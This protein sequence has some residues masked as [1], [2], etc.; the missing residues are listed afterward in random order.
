MSYNKLFQEVIKLIPDQIDI[1]D[2]VKAGKN[3]SGMYFEK[4][5]HIWNITEEQALN[6]SQ[7]LLIDSIFTLIHSKC[8]I[9]KS[10]GENIYRI[11]LNTEDEEEIKKNFF[12]TLNIEGN[13]DWLNDYNKSYNS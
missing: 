6:S 9:E 13:I 3:N 7:D 12:K 4:L 1:S 11:D 8:K 5:S 10:K 2:G